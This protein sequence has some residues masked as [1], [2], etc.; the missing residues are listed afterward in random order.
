MMTFFEKPP[1]ETTLY[2]DGVCSLCSKEIRMLRGA[3]D[4]NLYLKDIHSLSDQEAE[5]LPSKAELLLYLH[6]QTEEGRWLVGLDATVRAWQHT[7]YGKFFKV[8][9]IPGLRLI[10]DFCYKIW[11]KRRYEKNISGGLYR[12][13]SLGEGF[14]SIDSN[15]R[16]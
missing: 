5:G 12:L 4:D 15:R 8:L 16:S 1:P 3:C 13:C 2:Y 10:V 14:Y 11:A 9:R 6:A 7:S